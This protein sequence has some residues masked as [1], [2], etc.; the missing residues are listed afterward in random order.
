MDMTLGL[1]WKELKVS[2]RKMTLGLNWK[3]LKVSERNL[4]S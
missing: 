3:E 4:K 1:K 2:E